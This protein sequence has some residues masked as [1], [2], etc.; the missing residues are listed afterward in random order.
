MIRSR[1]EEPFGNAGLDM[2]GDFRSSSVWD[3]VSSTFVSDVELP[4]T[5]A[6]ACGLL[7][8]ALPDFVEPSLGLG[9]DRPWRVPSS[10][11]DPL[12]DSFPGV[13]P[14]LFAL[15][16]SRMPFSAGFDSSN[17]LLSLVGT[18]G[19]ALFAVVDR[20]WRRVGMVEMFSVRPLKKDISK[21]RHNDAPRQLKIMFGIV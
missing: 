1:S 16:S 9:A 19:A 17:I 13:V 2:M 14:L 4:P 20:S 6:T 10:R 5:D 3:I 21:G 8:E 11:L 18:A 12:T 15:L 7:G